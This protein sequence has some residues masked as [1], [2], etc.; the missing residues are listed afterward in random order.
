MTRVAAYVVLI[1]F[2]IILA[3]TAPSWQARTSVRADSVPELAVRLGGRMDRG[4]TSPVSITEGREIFTASCAGCH[5]SGNL[6]FGMAPLDS[7]PRDIY[8]AI[9]WGRSLGAPDDLDCTGVPIEPAKDHP[10]YPV[11]LSESERWAV[12][13]Y[14]HGL[15]LPSADITSD[16][17]PQQETGPALYERLCL[18]CHG[19]TGYGNGPLASDVLPSPTNLRDLPW[20]ACQSDDYLM[21][22]IRYGMFDYPIDPLQDE[23]NA[24]EWA[25]MPAWGTYLDDD[26]IVMLLAYIRS[27]SWTLEEPSEEDEEMENDAVLPDVNDWSWR[28]VTRT[29]EDHPEVRPDWLRW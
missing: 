2:A 14:V 26:A 25:G 19:V 3:S 29:L 4:P 22:V 16:G 27:F 9:T 23:S 17:S 5:G 21:S 7:S 12:S 10:V 18:N 11:A 8:Q 1:L 20:L 24:V 28:D 6:T 15:W 13:I